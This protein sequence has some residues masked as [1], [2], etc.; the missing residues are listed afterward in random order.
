MKAQA[1]RNM[2]EDEAWTDNWVRDGEGK[3]KTKEKGV[4]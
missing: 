1:R 4:K 3:I 2:E